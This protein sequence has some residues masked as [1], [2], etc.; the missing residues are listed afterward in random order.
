MKAGFEVLA[1]CGQVWYSGRR[2]SA[3]SSLVLLARHRLN[4]PV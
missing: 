3:E 2:R 4:S 1:L